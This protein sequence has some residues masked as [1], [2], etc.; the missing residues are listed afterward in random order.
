ML[1]I[2]RETAIFINYYGGFLL[3]GFLLFRYKRSLAWWA[4]FLFMLQDSAI[5]IWMDYLSDAS[6]DSRPAADWGVLFETYFVGLF[7]YGTTKVKQAWWWMY[8]CLALALTV[9]V[10]F[11]KETDHWSIVLS[12]FAQMMLCG[13][14]ILYYIQQDYAKGLIKMGAL[15]IIGGQLILKCVETIITVLYNTVKLPNTEFWSWGI[16]TIF[17]GVITLYLVSLFIGVWFFNSLRE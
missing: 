12:G 3:T 16:L 17:H 9:L 7:V 11:E 4:F 8:G 6:G 13:V 2:V 5:T 14:A 1:E 10:L 15:W